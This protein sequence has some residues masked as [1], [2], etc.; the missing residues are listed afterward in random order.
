MAALLLPQ[1]AVLE[2][3]T[4]GD[5][6]VSEEAIM[7]ARHSLDDPNMREFILSCLTLNPDKRPTAN[8]LLFHRVLFE[9]HSLKLL[10]AHC[11]INNQ[12]L[13]PENVVEEKI[14]ELDLNMVMAEIRREGRPGAQWSCLS[15]LCV[16]TRNGIYPLMNFAVSRPHAL[17]RALSQPQEDPQKAKTPTPEPFDVETRKVRSNPGGDRFSTG[18]RWTD[19][20]GLPCCQGTLQLMSRLLPTM[21]PESFQQSQ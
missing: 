7:R 16:C 2:I 9:V 11:F 1:M 6:R 4:N 12:Y 15:S 19:A 20:V 18:S 14:K 21:T 3:Q 8:N 17:P 5:T 10:A 13:M